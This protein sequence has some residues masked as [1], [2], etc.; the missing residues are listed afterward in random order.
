MKVIQVDPYEI[1]HQVTHLVP[2]LDTD[3]ELFMKVCMKCAKSAKESTKIL[4]PHVLKI[5]ILLLCKH[6]QAPSTL[7]VVSSCSVL[8]V[9]VTSIHSADQLHICCKYFF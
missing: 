2:L 6:K 7:T 5:C 9:S 4:F 8:E 1:T 3:K